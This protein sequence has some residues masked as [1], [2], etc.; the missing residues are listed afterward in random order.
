MSCWH[1]VIQLLGPF[2]VWATEMMVTECQMATDVLILKESMYR[3]THQW[4]H[5]KAQQQAKVIHQR[6]MSNIFDLVCL[7]LAMK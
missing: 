3:F 1:V 7:E 6:S 2:W 4:C 5:I